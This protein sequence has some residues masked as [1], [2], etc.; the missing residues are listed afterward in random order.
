MTR[1]FSIAL[2]LLS[3][4][5]SQFGTEALAHSVAAAKDPDAIFIAKSGLLPTGLAYDAMSQRFFISSQGDTAVAAITRDGAVSRFIEDPTLVSTIAIKVDA[6]RQRLLIT[7][8][9]PGKGARTRKDTQGKLAG[10]GIYDLTT[11]KPLSY[12]DLAALRPK[13]QHLAQDI[14]LDAEGNA[15]VTD[16]LSPLIYRVDLTGKASIFL[17]DDRLATAV[18]VYVS[19]VYDPAGYLILGKGDD[20]TLLKIP[21]ANPKALKP[22]VGVPKFLGVNNLVLMQDGKLA[23]AQPAGDFAGTFLLSSDDGWDSARIQGVRPIQTHSSV[24]LTLRDTDLTALYSPMGEPTA[25][26]NTAGELE[27]QK[28]N[29]MACP[30]D[31]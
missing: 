14:A 3:C 27:I 25:S 4:I 13:A 28:I 7:N 19:L 22:I 18:G 15:Y 26:D 1:K 21:L 10:L 31:Y 2:I 6:T 16:G 20:G 17:E 29:I 30:C 24:I 12:V 8:A 11:G 5:L 23:L 9:D